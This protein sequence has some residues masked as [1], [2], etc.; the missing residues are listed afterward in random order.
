VHG[1]ALM[2][3][4]RAPRVRSIHEVTDPAPILGRALLAL[5]T[6]RRTNPRSRRD[7]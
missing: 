7:D 4:L 3:E 1:D 5:Q 2:C 6:K